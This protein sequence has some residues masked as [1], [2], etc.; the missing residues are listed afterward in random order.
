M[1]HRTYTTSSTSSCQHKK[2]ESLKGP[3][4][5]QDSEGQDREGYAM[6]SVCAYTKANH[7]TAEAICSTSA[8]SE[9]NKIL[10]GFL[11]KPIKLLLVFQRQFLPRG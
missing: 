8:H 3:K 4:K 6:V 2:E 1:V 7:P 9:I 11:I 10:S 5:G